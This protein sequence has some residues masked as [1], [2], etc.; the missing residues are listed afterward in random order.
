MRIDY[1]THTNL[2]NDNKQTIDELC[3]ASC[4]RNIQEICI[5][6]HIDFN[7]KDICYNA[8]DWD[9]HIKNV[10]YANK[11]YNLKVICGGEFD[12]Q[13]IY[14]D[15]IK[16]MIKQCSFDYIM[17][18][19]HYCHNK[20]LFNH[21]E[22]FKG[23]E[24][25]EVYD[26]YFREELSVIKSGIFDGVSHFDL[27]KRTGCGIYGQFRPQNH[28]DIIAEC[29]K[30]IINNDMTLEVNSSGLRHTAKEIYPN[31][32][33]LRM[34]YDLGGKNITYGSDGHSYNQDAYAIDYVYD[35]LKSIG[36]KYLTV[37]RKRNKKFIDF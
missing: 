30:N 31:E 15:K 36:Y 11:N 29:L 7:P 20:V 8:F 14:M 37:Y 33:I 26:D 24:E 17:G 10:E 25:Q 35:L 18:S 27:I 13:F 34:Y 6:E 32:Y 21:P 3:Q 28:K 1:H 5:T 16:N 4:D 9:K 22:Y 19:C 12:A 2:S 23:R